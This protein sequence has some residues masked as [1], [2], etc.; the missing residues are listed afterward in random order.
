MK[1]ELDKFMGVLGDESS[2]KEMRRGTVM[3]GGLSLFQGFRS[4]ILLPKPNKDFLFLLRPKLRLALII[5]CRPGKQKVKWNHGVIIEKKREEV[6]EGYLS[7]L[8]LSPSLLPCPR[9]HG[10]GF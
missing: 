4:L 7:S 2:A 9:N 10:S 6:R 3:S 5:W 1:K 8:S